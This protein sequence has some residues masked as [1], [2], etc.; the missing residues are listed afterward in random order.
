MWKAYVNFFIRIL[1]TS[2]LSDKIVSR[3]DYLSRASDI[4][5]KFRKKFRY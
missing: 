3:R 1:Q 5:L 2:N 4:V